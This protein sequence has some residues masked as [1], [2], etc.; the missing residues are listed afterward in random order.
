[1]CLGGS[2]AGKTSLIKRILGE[3]FDKD[4]HPTDGINTELNCKVE[5]ANCDET[6]TRLEHAQHDLTEQDVIGGLKQEL[7]C[8]RVKRE[9]KVVHIP[10]TKCI[11]HS[12]HVPSVQRVKNEERMTTSEEKSD[13]KTSHYSQ[14]VEARKRLRK[15]STSKGEYCTIKIWDYAGQQVYY[16]THHIFI[17]LKCVYV[18]VV[19]LSK[20][21][22]STA[23]SHQIPSNSTNSEMK[24][25][26]EIE[27]W[28]NMILSSMRHSSPH[29]DLKNVIVVGTHKDLLD[30]DKAIQELK[31]N[32]YFEDLKEL[33]MNRAHLRIVRSFLA[34]DNKGEDIGGLRKIR[35]SIMEAIEEHCRWNEKRPIRWL[36]LEKRLQSL[37]YDRSLREINKHLVSYADVQKYGK[38]FNINTEDDLDTFLKYHHLTADLTYFEGDILGNYAVVDPQWLI[39]IFRAIIT[40]DEFYP[41]DPQFGQ[42]VQQLK[43][44]GILKVDGHLLKEV[45]KGIAKTDIDNEIKHYLLTLMTQ[46]DLAVKYNESC[47]L[48]PCLLPVSTGHNMTHQQ[49]NNRAKNC[50]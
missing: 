46:V 22:Q 34:V 11:K 48:M 38:A 8:Q 4:H 25:Y 33:L 15:I 40:L 30:D 24:Y 47:Y 28:L 32:Q 20:D 14:Q 29:E 36:L 50:T 1:M 7:T 41:K 49:K 13:Y 44:D 39:D 37:Q 2:G 6:W 3:G 23:S 5:I 16:N 45:W 12:E 27:F 35:N 18:L 17:R 26:Q 21:L 19:D 42:E 10:S 9:G 43:T 31:A